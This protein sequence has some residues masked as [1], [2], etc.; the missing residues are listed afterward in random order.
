[1]EAEAREILTTVC[2]ADEAKRPASSLQDLVD[3]LYGADKPEGISA[4][5]AG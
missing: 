1:M 4:I 5:L 3:E 2:R